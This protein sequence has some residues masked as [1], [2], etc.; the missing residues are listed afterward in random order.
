MDMEVLPNSGNLLASAHSRLVLARS[1]SQK[2][3]IAQQMKAK[4]HFLLKRNLK[5]P[6]SY[7]EE[8]TLLAGGSYCLNEMYA[9]G[10][11][12]Y[13][14]WIEVD[15]C[16]CATQKVFACIELQTGPP[17]TMHILTHYHNQIIIDQSLYASITYCNECDLIYNLPPHMIYTIPEENKPI[18]NCASE[19]ESTFDSDSN[20][21]N[22]DNENNDSSSAPNS[23][24]NDD[25]S[26]SNS[27]S[28]TFITFS[29]LFK[30][31]KLKWFSDNSKNI[32]P[33]HIH[34]T[35]AGFDLRY[36][37]KI[38]SN[39]NHIHTLALI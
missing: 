3:P 28:K 35:D 34:N 15:D 38:P 2:N 22:N 26:N 12:I 32:M 4:G 18:S 9:I 10:P 19:L 8:F 39:W 31:Q 25:D 11:G 17:F 1:D 14:N 36:S 27:N 13:E 7:L 30:E 37:G 33:E 16:L 5:V 21:N 20:S 29:D 24:E 6:Y 23:N